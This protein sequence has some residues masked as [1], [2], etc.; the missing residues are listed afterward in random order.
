MKKLILLTSIC[1]I[2]SITGKTQNADS[3]KSYIA[4]TSIVHKDI[5]FKQ[6]ML[7]TGNLKCTHCSRDVNN[8]LGWYYKKQY[9]K[10]DTWQESIDYCERWQKRH[11][12]GGDY[13]T[14]LVTRGYATDPNYIIKLKKQ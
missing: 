7:E 3:V 1:F 8:I 5:V 6:V 2:L 14:F 12:K 9:I 13:Y 10:F 11:Y 4:S